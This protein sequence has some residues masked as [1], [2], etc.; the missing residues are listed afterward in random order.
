MTYRILSLDGGGPWALIQACALAD[1][2]PNQSGHQ[3][4]KQF[5]CAIANS[6]GSITLAGLIKD[7][8]PTDI[9]GLFCSPA[10]RSRLFV[11]LWYSWFTTE[12]GLGPKWNTEKKFVGLREIMNAPGTPAVADVAFSN[13]SGIVGDTQIVITAYDYDLNREIFFCSRRS[14]L[15]NA[16][17]FVPTLAGA[18]HASADPP[19]NYFD[20]PANVTSKTGNPITR[21][22]WDGGVGG[23]NNPV[24][25]GVVEGLAQRVGHEDIIA[26]SIGS[27]M[28]WRPLGPPAGDADPTLFA[29]EDSPGIGDIKKM[30]EAILD[31]PPDAAT[32]NAHVVISGA[33]T[34]T[35]IIRLNPVIG[36]ES[37]N[38]AGWHLP[39]GFSKF[40]WKGRPID[41]LTAFNKLFA[42]PMDAVDQPSVDMIKA[43][44]GIWI[45]DGVG[46]Q[47]V[48]RDLETGDAIIGHNR[49]SLAR[50][51]WLALMG[52]APRHPTTPSFAKW[53]TR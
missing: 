41:A 15:A 6:G 9:A 39:D 13:L 10:D 18:V 7:L 47:P 51:A 44:A 25:H 48:Q 3:I 31:D 24:L 32:L 42:M 53:P 52:T 22:F 21:R 17:A 28:T 36:P 40:T 11:P 20:K 23:Y 14:P 4:L 26:L 43:L 46:N 5:N 27:A 8:K 12:L 16:D 45:A 35:R 33:D 29:K 19:V 38:G 37:I 34:K 50:D 2:F 49:Y 1:I 30:A